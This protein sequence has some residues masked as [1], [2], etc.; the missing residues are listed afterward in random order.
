M[1]NLQQNQSVKDTLRAGKVLTVTVTTGSVGVSIPSAAINKTITESESFGYFDKDVT[2]ELSAFSGTV[3]SFEIGDTVPASNQVAIL[4]PAQSARPDITGVVASTIRN[5]ALDDNANDITGI[6]PNGF[7]TSAIQEAI[8]WSKNLGIV[9]VNLHPGAEY[10]YDT[11]LTMDLAYTRL[12]GNG[13]TIFADT[14]GINE[15]VLTV[16]YNP[17]V[18][19]G[20][21]NLWADVRPIQGLSIIN[22]VG[23]YQ[24]PGST[25]P[26][27]SVGIYFNGTDVVAG[28]RPSLRNVLVS[29]FET[30][31]DGLS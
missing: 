5:Q 3:A 4:T 19:G 23:L 22:R 15:K 29:G 11:P 26:A 25:L 28:I 13:A 14:I 9:V 20:Y 16:D 12:N 1:P 27:G 17:P 6:F 24:Y 18:S 30:L 8:D 21:R 10:T 31:I 7:T 2:F